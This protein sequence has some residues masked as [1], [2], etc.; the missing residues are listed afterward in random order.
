MPKKYE[1]SVKKIFNSI[2]EVDAAW[3]NELWLLKSILIQKQKVNT[4]EGGN[5]PMKKVHGLWSIFHA[6][7]QENSI[8]ISDWTNII[9]PT[10][11]SEF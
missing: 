4:N 6:I 7:K 9:S 5:K 8:L 10:E 3:C 2:F 11:R 1:Y